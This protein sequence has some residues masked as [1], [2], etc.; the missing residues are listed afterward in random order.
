MAFD[1]QVLGNLVG[2]SQEHCVQ[3]LVCSR[4]STRRGSEATGKTR[5][6][7]SFCSILCTMKQLS[8]ISVELSGGTQGQGESW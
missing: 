2:E 8:F 6:L 4:S 3:S 5:E 7:F 1:C